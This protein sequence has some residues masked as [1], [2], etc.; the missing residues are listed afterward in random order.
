M[1]TTSLICLISLSR[2]AAVALPIAT[3]HGDLYRR[4]D[5]PEAVFRRRSQQGW[6]AVHC[7][8]GRVQRRR[9]GP[10]REV[11]IQT[12]TYS[13]IFPVLRLSVSSRILPT[14]STS[15]FSAHLVFASVA[16]G[17][18]SLRA[19]RAGSDKGLSFLMRVL[20]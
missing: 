6:P 19:G 16:A 2:R 12:G 14:N 10:R 13:S 1:L 8:F 5:D 7:Q 11:W 20:T 4:E 17:I 3:H 18:T 9:S 15:V